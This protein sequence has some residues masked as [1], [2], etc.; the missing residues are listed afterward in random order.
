MVIAILMTNGLARN[1]IANGIEGSTSVT[2]ED[3]L[4]DFDDAYANMTHIPDADRFISGWP[5]KAVEFRDAWP[6]K[7]LDIA[8]GND[9]RQRF[10]LFYPERP[11]KGLVVF[12]HGGYWR[13]FAK[14]DWSHLAA[15][16]L[17]RGFAVAL[18]SY[19][20]APQVT[21]DKICGD[22]AAAV[23]V[24]TSHVNGPIYLAGHSAGGHLV[25]RLIS[26]ERLL[27]PELVKRIV[28]VTSIS[29][30]HDLRPL[31]FTELNNLLAITDHIAANES[32]ALLT[33]LPP[34]MAGQ[35]KVS[36][37]VGAEERPEFFRQT[38]LL[39]LSWGG[40]G[41]P[42]TVRHE[43]DR[44]HFNVIDGLMDSNGSLISAILENRGSR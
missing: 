13:A 33:P 29:G 42:V 27:S 31:L 23:T 2:K 15:G 12:I 5:E 37:W 4:M 8:Y 14:D 40:F 20:L 41:V 43:K 21:L 11:A 6:Q 28:T 38:D 18:P 30:V 34:V 35:I 17:G 36:V 25:T 44:H 22:A 32:P 7:Q 10:D 16:A 9:P 3:A 26:G 39:A 24:A 19:R 1:V